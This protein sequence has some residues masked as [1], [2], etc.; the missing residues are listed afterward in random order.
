MRK[1]LPTAASCLIA[2]LGLSLTA[3][4]A[5]PQLTRVLPRGGQRGTEVELTFDGARLADAQEVLLYEPGITFGPVQQ[6]TDAK[7]A[8]KLVKVTAKIAPDA[9]LGQY[10]LRL[11]TATGVSELRTFW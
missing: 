11:R 1:N 6:P 2:L 4:A 3:E 7:Q 5:S 10:H 8:G 9:R